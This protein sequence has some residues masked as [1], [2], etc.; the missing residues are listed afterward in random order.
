[1]TRDNA[2]ISDGAGTTGIAARIFAWPA[3]VSVSC[4]LR[5]T[6]PEMTVPGGKA[7]E[8]PRLS[9]GLASRR[10]P[11]AIPAA[12]IDVGNSPSE[13]ASAAHGV[14]RR[15][16]TG[17]SSDT[18]VPDAADP[19]ELSTNA[20]AWLLAT[21]LL[22]AMLAIMREIFERNAFAER[23]AYSPDEAAELLGISRE[24]VHDLL[25]TG[26]LRSVK[27]GRRRLIAKHHLEAFLA[28]DEQA[29]P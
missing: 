27:A 25:R 8:S 20:I 16:P 4:P 1:V 19:V 21:D 3:A 14:R 13:Q 24:L 15:R 7:E 5:H 29:S 11:S 22:E 10:A 9:G 12:T 17:R 18:A 23:L 28:A 6:R 2:A 26:Q